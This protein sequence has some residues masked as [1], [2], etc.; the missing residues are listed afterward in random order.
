MNDNRAKL[1]QDRLDSLF[2]NKMYVA[3]STPDKETWESYPLPDG[4]RYGWLSPQPLG[5][6]DVDDPQWMVSYCPEVIADQTAWLDEDA[7]SAYLDL[8]EAVILRHIALLEEQPGL[9][10]TER[11]R[12]VEDEIIDAL[13]DADNNVL[14][15]YAEVQMRVLDTTGS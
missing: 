3:V 9:T 14:A 15:L 11:S 2:L 6:D 1:I 12:M 13:V 10:D 5:S 4:Y 7:L 8:T